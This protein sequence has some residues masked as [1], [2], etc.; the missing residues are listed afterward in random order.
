MI[1]NITD[2]ATEAIELSVELGRSSELRHEDEGREGMMLERIV[3]GTGG[4]CI[5]EPESRARLNKHR[6]NI[7]HKVVVFDAGDQLIKGQ[8]SRLFEPWNSLPHFVRCARSDR[9][10]QVRSVEME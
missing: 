9:L 3:G 6:T 2:S 4:W 5:F 7:S 1:L 10:Y 8:L